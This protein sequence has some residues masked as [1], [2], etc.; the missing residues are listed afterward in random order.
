MIVILILELSTKYFDKALWKI[1]VLKGEC[2][3]KEWCDLLDSVSCDAA[4]DGG[5]K[6][7]LV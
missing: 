5:Y 2:R 3:S 4:T 7:C 6:K 1:D